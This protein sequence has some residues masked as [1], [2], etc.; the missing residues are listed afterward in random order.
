MPSHHIQPVRSIQGELSLP[1]DKSIA[2][3]SI[4]ISSIAKG[5]TDIYNFPTNQ[6]C[7]ITFRLFRKLGV[8]ISNINREDF[9]LSIE[10]KG[11]YGLKRA[12]SPLSVNESGTTFRL[13]LGILAGQRFSTTLI[14]AHSLARRPMRRVTEPLRRMGAIIK[15]RR[16]IN[17]RSSVIK[18]RIEEYPP[19]TIKGGNLNRISYKMAVASA[20]VKSALLLAALYAKGTTRILEPVKTRDHTE[21]MLKN[22]RANIRIENKFI[23]LRGQ[24]ELT[25]P[26]KIYIPGD[27]SSA[28]FFIVAA[29]LLPHSYLVLRSVGVNPTRIGLIRILRRMGADIRIVPLGASFSGGEPVADVIV[30]SSKL[31]GVR[32]SSSEVPQLID[33]LSILMLASCFAEGQTV[34]CGVEELRVKETD[35]ILSMESNLK[36]MGAEI[37]VSTYRSSSGKLRERIVV[38]G[39]KCLRG[40]RVNSFGDHRTAMS[41]VIAGLIAKGR[42]VIDDVDCIDKSFPGFLITLRKIIK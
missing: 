20:Q 4:I 8:R 17:L 3:R 19:I 16:V 34:I 41:M 1:G 6:D 13:L 25:S 27:I 35:R 28:S 40:A 29:I 9:T 31:R 21:R 12:T 37:F 36:R 33:E 38:R 23:L 26:G 2:H 11:L 32:V 39:V 14:T 22:F 24:N 42:T 5:K 10:G 7:L 18:E 30:R 15:A